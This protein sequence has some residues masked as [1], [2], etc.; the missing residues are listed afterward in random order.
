[1]VFLKAREKYNSLIQT[2]KKYPRVG[3]A[4]SGGVDSTLLY[5]AAREA[6]G[7]E[8]VVVLRAVS[9]IIS[10]QEQQAAATLLDILQSLQENIVTVMLYPLLRPEFVNNTSDRCYLC[11]KQMYRTFLLE[12]EKRECTTL[13][14]GSNVDDLKSRRPGFKAIHELGVQT[15]LLDAG[16]SKSEIRSLAVSLDLSNH[17]KPSN[18]CLAT[19]IPEGTVITEKKLRLVEECET[20]LLSRGFH[21]CRVRVEGEDAVLQIGARDSDRLFSQDRRDELLYFMQQLGFKRVLC[22][23]RLRL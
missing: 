10:A 6:I 8:N 17:D 16:L 20:F 13:L 15:P 1:M 5:C 3:V 9:A 7:E 19:R 14:D 18:S 22:D 4:F 23:L 12:L 2:L 21:G 11:K